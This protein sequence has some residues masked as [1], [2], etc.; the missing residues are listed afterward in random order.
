[1]SCKS[2]SN[3]DGRG[4]L[5]RWRLAVD[6]RLSILG[7]PKAVEATHKQILIMFPKSYASTPIASIGPSITRDH[8]RTSEVRMIP[9]PALVLIHHEGL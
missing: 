5:A 8:G 6:L 7:A 1:M 3:F 4:I 9:G 2:P